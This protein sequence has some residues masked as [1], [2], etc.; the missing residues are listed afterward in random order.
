MLHHYHFHHY[1]HCEAQEPA[2]APAAANATTST[3]V[4]V[5]EP[6]DSRPS[7]PLIKLSVT[8]PPNAAI[9]VEQGGEEGENR[10]EFP[11]LLTA[12]E[13]HADETCATVEQTADG[14]PP[15]PV[16]DALRA[17]ESAKVETPTGQPARPSFKVEEVETRNEEPPTRIPLNTQ[18]SIMD[19]NQT[20]QRRVFLQ[21]INQLKRVNTR[22]MPAM[23]I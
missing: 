1:Y 7:S 3:T 2:I 20:D 16:S 19:A 13:C 9:S 15:A 22:R 6:V 11:R 17:I 23:I 12:G 18:A 4:A 21:N 8:W 10:S 5:A 14:D